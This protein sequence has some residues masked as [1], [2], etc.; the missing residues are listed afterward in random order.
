MKRVLSA[1]F[2]VCLFLLIVGG[3][4]ATFDRY[5]SAMPDWD[6]WDA[7]ALELLIPWFENENFIRHL[8]HPHNEHRV[9]MTKLQNLALV[10]LNG[11]WDSRLEAATNALLHAGL[12][13]GFWLVGRRV[14][15]ARWQVPLFV[16]L[17]ALFGLP[18]AWQNVLGGFH[19]QQYWL[20]G[21]SFAAIVSVPFARTGS[22]AWWG[23]LLAA[24]LALGTMASGFIA[25]AVVLVVLGW[26]WWRRALTWRETWPTWVLM[27]ACVA[28]GLLTRVEVEWHRDLKAKTVHDFVFTIVHSLQWPWREK[29]WAAVLLWLPWAAVAWGVGRTALRRSRSGSAGVPVGR[30]S[31]AAGAARAPREETALAILALGLWVLVQLVATAYAR[32]RGADYPASRYMDTLTFGAAVNVLALGW[33]LSAAWPATR[34]RL[35]VYGLGLAWTLTLS[36]GLY[37]LLAHTVRWELAD[38]KKY[39][40]K[41]ESN[42]R[43]YLASNDPKELARPEI[44]FPSA[45]GL[46]E[47]LARPSLRQLMAAPLRAPLPLVAATGNNAGFLENDA[48]LDDSETPPRRGLSPATAPLDALLTWGSFGPDGLAGQ[49]VWQSQ[50]LTSR[51]PWLKFETAG[52]V[53]PPY[54]HAVS[55]ALHDAATGVKVAEVFPTRRPHDTW[56]AAYV[57]TPEKPFVVVATDRSAGGWVAFSGPVEMGGASYWAWRATKHGLLIVYVAGMAA[58]GLLGVAWRSR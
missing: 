48:R 1:A 23:G 25:A 35:A 22:M 30:T 4:W 6:Q 12:A 21:L 47:R 45:E 42:M 34:T 29:H 5:G 18:V 31:Y 50:P 55:L 58:L 32:G 49:G 36:M 43:R 40:L 2:A 16:L 54:N 9:I 24:V 44:P 3:K 15:A 10:L 8:V 46:I 52:D 11:Q 19:S 20:A 38:A 57:R 53:G 27:A 56:R 7:E 51:F 13:V 39:Y 37:N 17:A 14:M 28:V 41:A 26:R 33:L